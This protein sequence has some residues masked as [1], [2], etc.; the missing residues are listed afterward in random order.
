MDLVRRIGYVWDIVVLDDFVLI[1][2][3]RSVFN[4][5]INKPADSSNMPTH[6]AERIEKWHAS[7]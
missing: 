7:S 5:A 6:I 2:Q 3:W 1:M 4:K